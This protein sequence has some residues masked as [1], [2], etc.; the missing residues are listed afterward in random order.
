MDEGA[1]CLHHWVIRITPDELREIT[2]T[3]SK[4]EVPVVPPLVC[5][6]DIHI[7]DSCERKRCKARAR[8]ARERRVW[9]YHREDR[10]GRDPETGRTGDGTFPE[11]VVNGLQLVCCFGWLGDS[12][13][14]L[15]P[16][17]AQ[18]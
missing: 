12:C 4:E 13:A 16:T 5:E 11:P 1:R 18:G 8:E 9:A 3:G 7:E 17:E 6:A 15:D 14:C 2:I 10:G